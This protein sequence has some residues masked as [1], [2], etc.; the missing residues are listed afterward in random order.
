[1]TDP[2]DDLEDN[3]CDGIVN[4]GFDD[5]AAGCVCTPG[6]V[7]PCYDGPPGTEGVGVC[8]GGTRTCETTGR[9]FRFCAGQVVPSLDLCGNGVDEDCDGTADN[10]P[11]QD[12]DGWTICDGDCCDDPLQGC[13][14]P[15]LVNPGAIEFPGN[16]VDDDCDGTVDNPTP[17]CDGTLAAN[18]SS[19]LDYA[20]AMDLCQ[21]TTETAPIGQ[22]SWGVISA[23]FLL[24]DGTG[25]PNAAARSIRTTFGN[26]IVP[27]AGSSLASIS[28]GTA[29]FPSSAAPTYS[30]VQP[31]LDVTQ[32][33]SP[34]ADWLAANGGNLPNAPGCP[35]P[36]GGNTAND[37]IM[38]QL[39]IRVPTNAN[40]FSF[41]SYFLSS[42]Y[43]EWVCSA[44]NDF[45]VVLLDSAFAGMPAN[46][47]DKNLA[48]YTDPMGVEYPVGVNLA[49]GD[50]GLFTQCLNG[51]TGCG[52]GAVAGNT[53]TCAGTLDL[54]GTGYDQVNAPP[55]FSSDPTGCGTSNLAGGGTGWLTTSGNVVPGEIIELRIM[56]WDT[57]DGFYDS[58]ALLD[59]FVW[60][61][62]A[63]NPGTD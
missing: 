26:N 38:L 32:S 37:P 61:V 6:F 4:N 50:T 35:A 40:S 12:G 34:P 52:S 45:F 60:N 62:N 56:V 21:T 55:A 43:P 42:E 15:A 29:A 57:G 39:R 63:S 3:D 31:G 14:D 49:F 18:S 10:P 47:A 41:N 58:T 7:E 53:T 17:A 24:P 2:C 20:R 51:P 23:Q 30:A 5:G 59:N 13:A 22:R 25:A 16:Q 46:P 44:F 36:Q 9:N 28:T 11:D 19:A 27:Q 54:S 48:T 8:T 1:M 33:S